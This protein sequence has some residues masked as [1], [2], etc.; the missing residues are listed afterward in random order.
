MNEEAGNVENRGKNKHELLL[1]KKNGL[2]SQ[3]L[4]KQITKQRELRHAQRQPG[5]VSSEGNSF[6]E[7]LAKR[8]K[9]SAYSNFRPFL[10]TS[11]N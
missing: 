11:C 7:Q 5:A 6:A 8:C 10:G 1:V 9:I 4:Y 2:W 3:C